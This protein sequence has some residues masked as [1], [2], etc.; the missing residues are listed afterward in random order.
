MPNTADRLIDSFVSKLESRGVR[1]EKADNSALVRKLEEG[2]P[3]RLPRSF[4]SFLSRFSFA[5]FDAGGIEFF[6]W[7]PDSSKIFEIL[8]PNKGTLSELL[9]PLGYIQIGQPDTGDFDAICFD[10]N[11]AKQNR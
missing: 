5:P 2:L 11:M 1:I 7:G 8:P 10:T 4:A 3:K 6:G 9:L